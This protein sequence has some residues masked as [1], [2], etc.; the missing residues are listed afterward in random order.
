MAQFS[1]GGERRALGRA[2]PAEVVAG[3]DGQAWVQAAFKAPGRPMVCQP[4]CGVA[5][6]G[7]QA[8]HQGQRI[9]GVVAQVPAQ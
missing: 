6:R 4:L 9:R 3:R 2:P 1:F 8:R 5:L 7:R